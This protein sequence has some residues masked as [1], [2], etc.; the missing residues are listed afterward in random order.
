MTQL[1]MTV[2][3]ALFIIRK[4]YQRIYISDVLGVAHVS[5]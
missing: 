5:Q 4:R 2:A 1:T 3:L